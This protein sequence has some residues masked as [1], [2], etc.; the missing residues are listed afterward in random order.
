MR[1]GPADCSVVVTVIS[2]IYA[3]IWLVSLSLCPIMQTSCETKSYWMSNLEEEWDSSPKFLKGV[4]VE[5][6]TLTSCFHNRN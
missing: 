1:A 4:S 5:F 3:Y 6:G 2:V